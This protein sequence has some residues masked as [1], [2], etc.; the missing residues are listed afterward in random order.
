MNRVNGRIDLKIQ[1]TEQI[2]NTEKRK[3]G[4]AK[5]QVEIEDVYK[6]VWQKINIRR[7]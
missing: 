2:E 1:N 3:T 4:F 7:E 5:E 6:P